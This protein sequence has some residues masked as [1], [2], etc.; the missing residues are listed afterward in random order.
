MKF[1]EDQ[2]RFPLSATATMVAHS[3][4]VISRPCRCLSFPEGYEQVD[5]KI[6]EWIQRA[7]QEINPAAAAR[8]RVS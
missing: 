5:I 4:F 6:L 2:T 3:P 8:C 1:A 7:P